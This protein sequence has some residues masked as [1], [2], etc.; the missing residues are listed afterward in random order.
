MHLSAY[1]RAQAAEQCSAQLPFTLRNPGP[2]PFKML[3]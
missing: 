2:N 1:K 3:M